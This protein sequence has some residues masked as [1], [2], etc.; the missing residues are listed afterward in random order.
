[1]FAF[2]AEVIP[3]VTLFV[4]EFTRATTDELAFCI[5]DSVASEP[6][7]NPAPVNVLVAADQTSDAN[8]PNVVSERVPADQTALGI[9]NID[10]VI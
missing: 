2:T 4:F 1:M 10:E 8:A 7:S 5:S 9:A 3:E 6:V